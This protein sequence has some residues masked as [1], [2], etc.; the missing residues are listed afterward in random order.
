M[1][2]KLYEMVFNLNMMPPNGRH[3]HEK[4]NVKMI[5]GMALD[6]GCHHQME[7]ALRR[8]SEFLKKN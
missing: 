3:I 7:A 5:V 8:V 2:S 4:N 1:E 6:S